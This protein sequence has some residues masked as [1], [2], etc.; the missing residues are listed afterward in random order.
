MGATVGQ[1][2]AI[3]AG[4]HACYNGRDNASQHREV[5]SI[6]KPGRSRDRGLELTR[7]NLE[8]HI[9]RDMRQEIPSIRVSLW[10]GEYV[11]ASCTHRPSLHASESGVRCRPL[12]D[13]ESWARK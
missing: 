9:V 2:A 13:N 8:L 3:W 12:G 4:P 5:K 10:R 6:A 1:Y 11:P 7:V